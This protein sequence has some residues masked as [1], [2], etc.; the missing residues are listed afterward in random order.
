MSLAFT[1]FAVVNVKMCRYVLILVLCAVPL[2]LRAQEAATAEATDTAESA[3][4]GVV[5][6][7]INYFRNSNKVS[8]KTFDCSVVAGPFYN[9]T[10]SFAIGGG[11][12]ALYTWDKTDPTLTRS[13]LSA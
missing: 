3:K 7:V 1:I 2:G 11:I 12:S 5:P 6:K 9:A 4:K 8:Q 10:T 13:S